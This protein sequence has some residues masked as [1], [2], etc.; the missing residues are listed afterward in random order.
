MQK[1]FVLLLG[2]AILMLFALTIAGSRQDTYGIV[3]RHA[4]TSLLALEKSYTVRHLIEYESDIII[5]DAVKNALIVGNDEPDQIRE[6]IATKLI[7]YATR[8]EYAQN[9]IVKVRFYSLCC[10]GVSCEKNFVVGSKLQ[11]KHIK[12]AVKVVLLKPSKKVRVAWVIVTGA[13]GCTVGGVL[14]AK[15]TEMI[16]ML[17]VGY[18][19]IVVM[20]G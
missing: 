6:A 10:K 15:N 13:D 17:P 18:Q 11:K 9:G 4:I 5:H 1:G 14:Q 3:H 19:Q 8:R 7:K 20:I 2:T 16:Y 12:D